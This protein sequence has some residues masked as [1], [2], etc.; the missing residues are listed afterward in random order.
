MRYVVLFFVL[1]FALSNPD[2]FSNM[3]SKG[4]HLFS[5]TVNTSISE[6]K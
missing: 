4:V 5:N 6:V 2:G 1:Y 3:V